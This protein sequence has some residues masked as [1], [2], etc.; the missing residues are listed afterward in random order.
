MTTVFEIA[1]PAGSAIVPPT[2]LTV[3]LPLR[4]Y[5]TI[6][7]LV[8][9]RVRLRLSME[10]VRTAPPGLFG[11]LQRD[12][13]AVPGIRS[14]RVNVAAL[15]VTIEFDPDRIPPHWWSSLLRA[16]DEEAHRLLAQI[17]PSAIADRPPS[18]AEEAEGRS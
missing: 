10:G 14:L 16:S 8:R 6:V 7:H 17:E 13:A 15:S 2:W 9:G 18:A 12:V 11:R 3:L 5:L 4:R 1:Q